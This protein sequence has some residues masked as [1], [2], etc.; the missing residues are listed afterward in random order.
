L[1]IPWVSVESL[2]FLLSPTRD[3]E[4]AKRFLLKALGACVDSVPHTERIEEKMA[5]YPILSNHQA[6]R[7]APRVINVDK[8]AAYPKAMPNSKPVESFLHPLTSDESNT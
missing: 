1:R 8:N 6:S 5:Q 7:Q 3:A 4:A 2:E